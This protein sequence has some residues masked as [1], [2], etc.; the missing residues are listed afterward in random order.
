MNACKL[1]LSI[2]GKSLAVEFPADEAETWF[3]TLA[4]ALLKSQPEF[5]PE[6]AETDDP[7]D[8]EDL[9]PLDESDKPSDVPE[10]TTYTG[11][12]RIRC[13]S[14]GQ[15]KNFCAK[16]PISYYRCDCGAN[17]GLIDLHRMNAR[18]NS[19]GH[20][21]SY[22]TNMTDELDE[23]TCLECG[24][25]ITLEQDKFGDYHTIRR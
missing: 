10:S 14:C 9:K 20:V 16:S 13:N 21:W 22:R 5:K 18:C 4:D 1:R 8:C 6:A 7:D 3:I 2:P 23:I 19:C 11:F 15:I 25:P 12:L 24:A 17:T